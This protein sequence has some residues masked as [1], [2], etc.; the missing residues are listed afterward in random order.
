MT[1]E[2]T[3]RAAPPHAA[4]HDAPPHDPLDPRLPAPHPLPVVHHR[5]EHDLG[6]YRA[7]QLDLEFS[8]G[9]RRRYERLKARGRGAVIIC[10]LRD[11]ATALLVREYSCG[12]HRYELGLPKGKIDAGETPLDAALRELKEEA[13]VGARRLTL[14]RSLTLAPT[15]MDHATH[16]VVAEDLYPERLPGDEPEPLDVIEWPLAELHALML[17][18][19]VSEGRSLAGLFVVREWLAQGRPDPSPAAQAAAGRRA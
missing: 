8:N 19:D 14:L 11:D 2:E 4:P 3:T 7:E 10:A 16:L 6:P 5:E 12:V 17:R 15:Y 13:G 18:E 9:E 1:H